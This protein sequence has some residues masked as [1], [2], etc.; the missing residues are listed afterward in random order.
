[1]KKIVILKHG[2]G[3]LANQLWNYVSIYAYS[4]ECGAKITNAS[5]FEYH[6]Y[7]KFINKEGITTKFFSCWFKSAV[8]RRS[9]LRN[10]FWRNTYIIYTGIIKLFVGKN[11]ISSENKESQVVYLPPTS[12][13]LFLENK[14]KIYFIGWLFR[15]PVGLKKF[16]AEIISAFTPNEAMERKVNG[17]VRPLRQKYEKIVGVHVRQSDY[18]T[19]KGG[20]YFIS[21]NRVKEIIGEFMVNDSIDKDKI[22]FLITSDGRI[23]EKIFRDINTY[24]SKENAI[25]DLFLL[26]STDTVI[27]SDSSFGAFAA[28]YGN[29]PHIVMTKNPIDWSYYAG[30]KEYFENQYSNMVHY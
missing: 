20:A 9:S 4:L 26:S 14:E 15:N 30:K 29:V 1:M 12:P 3:E 10:R 17:I 21:Q 2:G 28:W 5:F 16:R 24:I 7:F 6:Y 18:S 27:G 25:T 13:L 19:F 22:L 8:S 11:I 23:D